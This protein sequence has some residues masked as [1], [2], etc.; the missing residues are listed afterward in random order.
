MSNQNLQ[1]I[2]IGG[3]PGIGKSTLAR[4]LK[5]EFPGGVTLE[6]DMLWSCINAVN[7]HDQDQGW[8]SLKQSLFLAQKYL[9]SGFSPVTVV[10]V[11]T[12]RTLERVFELLEK[13]KLFTDFKIVSLYT[14]EAELKRRVVNR[15]SGWKDLE[16]CYFCN[17]DVQTQRF[18]NQLLIDTTDLD[19]DAVR[20]KVLMFLKE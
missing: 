18:E 12:T 6:S 1:V 2:F 13:V 8:E 7:W 5:K 3:A 19:Q 9:K 20:N 15:E 17:R 10:N 4:H 11:F 14:S 16:G